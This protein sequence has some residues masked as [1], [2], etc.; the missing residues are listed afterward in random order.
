MKATRYFLQQV[1]RKRPEIEVS[2]CLA[3]LAF[4]LQRLVQP[5]GRIRHWDE[6]VRPGENRPRI[7]GVVTLDDGETIHNAFIDRGFRKPQT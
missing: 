5:D 3:V 4:P 2:A 1:L 6:I 7:L